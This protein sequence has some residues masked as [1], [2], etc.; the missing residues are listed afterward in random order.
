MLID[1][2]IQEIDMATPRKPTVAASPTQA[3][4]AATQPDTVNPVID[5]EIRY[6]YIQVA[7]YY[8]A[9]RRGFAEGSAEQDWAQAERE[10]DRL[11]A[12]NKLIP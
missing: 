8:I 9:E 1:S 5:P 10:I 12:E 3:I 2:V 6:R 7:A 11:L 4:A